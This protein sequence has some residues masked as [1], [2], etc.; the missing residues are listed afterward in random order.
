M[1]RMGTVQTARQ[2]VQ[3]AHRTAPHPPLDAHTS[4]PVSSPAHHLQCEESQGWASEHARNIQWR[5]DGCIDKKRTEY[6]VLIDDKGDV[7]MDVVT[8]FLAWYANRPKLQLGGIKMAKNWILVCANIERSKRKLPVLPSGTANSWME[9]RV[10]EKE[11]RHAQGLQ[12]TLQCADTSKRADHVPTYDEIVACMR[13]CYAGDR[14]IH[15]DPLACLQTGFELRVLHTSGVRGQVVRTATFA[16]LWTRHYPE[17]AGGYGMT[18]TVMHNV[19]R[20]KTNIEGDGTHSG[21]IAS[22]NALLC[23]DGALGTCL[24]YRVTHRHEPFPCVTDDHDG[25]CPGHRYKWLPLSISTHR[26]Y[27]VDYA[28][29]L[30]QHRCMEERS[31]NDNFNLM[32]H[33]AGM[34]MVVGDAVTHSGR[35]VAQQQFQDAGGDPRVSDEA[36]GYQ[37]RDA[38]KDHYTPHIPIQFQLQ[39]GQFGLLDPASL[40][41]ADAAHLC[42]LRTHRSAISELIDLVLPEL[43]KEEESVRKLA[44]PTDVST[45]ASRTAQ[46]KMVHAQ[47]RANAETHVR[48]HSNFLSYVR[49]IVSLSIVCAASRP[50]RADGSIDLSAPSLVDDLGHGGIYSG[51]RIR[52][53]GMWLYAHPTFRLIAQEVRRAEDGENDVTYVSPSRRKTAR[54]VAAELKP[55]F[56]DIKERTEK[57]EGVASTALDMAASAGTIALDTQCGMRALQQQLHDAERLLEY[58][59]LEPPPRPPDP[60]S[61]RALTSSN[62]PG[63]FRPRAVV[64]PEVPEVPTTTTTPPTLPAEA[65]PREV[66]RKRPASPELE[67]VPTKQLCIRELGNNVR[68]LWNEYAGAGGIC[69][70]ERTTRGQWR[71]GNEDNA[72]WK[73]KIFIYREIARQEI[74]LGSIDAALETTQQRVDRCGNFTKFIAE[75]KREEKASNELLKWKGDEYLQKRAF[76]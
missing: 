10:V 59:G 61:I 13:L 69:H 26:S 5:D 44:V 39:R 42:V 57:S 74:A 55:V 11:S 60:N 62:F 73:K 27:P 16:H 34:Q 49:H 33:A 17:L 36:L 7:L 53:T 48:E 50:R 52:Q 71:T 12:K 54:A 9:S 20:G 40:A 18:S 19:R 66:E 22:K 28:K 51:I 68:S 56:E 21:W 64:A 24:L 37:L 38:S 32:Y 70:R 47:K 3:G 4:L 41:E 8:S 30:L 31:Q 14:R 6:A 65:P 72:H 35:H 46:L 58:N 2:G 29:G 25:T 45:N 23:P 75:L 63:V 15:S 67:R 43:S 76:A 1:D